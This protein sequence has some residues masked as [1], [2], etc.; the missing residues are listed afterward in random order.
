MLRKSA[1]QRREYLVKKSLEDREKS[2]FDRK[3]RLRQALEA[4]VA[5]PTDLQ[6]KSGTKLHKVFPI[7]ISRGW[8]REI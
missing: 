6:N 7:G 8:Y 3:E 4:G 1:R 5:V 2:T